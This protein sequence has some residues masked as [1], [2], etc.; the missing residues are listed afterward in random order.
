MSRSFL[1]TPFYR[2]RHTESDLKP[3]VHGMARARLRRLLARDDWDAVG[4]DPNRYDY[5]RVWWG[6]E[7]RM[8]FGPPFTLPQYPRYRRRSG[9]WWPPTYQEQW[10]DYRRGLRK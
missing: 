3:I 8:W 1:R 2:S 5:L 7:Y 9:D 10:D 6:K 4:Y